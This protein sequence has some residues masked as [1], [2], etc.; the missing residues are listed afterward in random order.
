[1]RD[2]ERKTHPDLVPYEGLSD[3]EKEYDRKTSLETLR[4]I[5]S[6]GYRISKSEQS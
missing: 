1:M 3:S 6:L 4:V 5:L 2:S